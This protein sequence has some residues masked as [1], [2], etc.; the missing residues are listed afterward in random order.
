VQA[1]AQGR[2]LTDG[3]LSALQAGLAN[4]AERQGLRMALLGTGV[5][6]V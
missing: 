6:R 1:L 5:I 4:D 3:S 2:A